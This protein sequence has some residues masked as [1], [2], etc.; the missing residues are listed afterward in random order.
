METMMTASNACG[1]AVRRQGEASAAKR[2]SERRGDNEQRESA[3]VMTKPTLCSAAGLMVA[4]WLG[5]ER[6]A[7]DRAASSMTST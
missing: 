3:T 5:F 2:G 7:G 4:V 1:P 6:R